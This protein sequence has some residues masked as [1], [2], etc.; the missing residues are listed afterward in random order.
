MASAGKRR[1]WTL[2]RRDLH[3]DVRPLA[4]GEA[5][6]LLRDPRLLHIGDDARLDA[7]QRAIDLVRPGSVDARLAGLAE[8]ETAQDRETWAIVRRLADRLASDTEHGR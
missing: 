3:L 8:G 7:W 6:A 5:D 4:D 1:G 2:L